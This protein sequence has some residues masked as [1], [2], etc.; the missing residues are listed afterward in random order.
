MARVFYEVEIARAALRELRGG[1]VPAKLAA[2]W[3]LEY[4]EELGDASIGWVVPLLEYEK[5]TPRQQALCEVFGAALAVARVAQRRRDHVQDV[6][7]RAMRSV[8]EERVDAVLE[9][10]KCERERQADRGRR[11]GYR[12]ARDLSRLMY[13][14]HLGNGG[15]RAAAAFARDLRDQW[16]PAAPDAFGLEPA[17]SVAVRL[18]SLE[19]VTDWLKPLEPNT[20]RR[21]RGR[22]RK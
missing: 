14:T 1:G 6:A 15:R 22:P 3:G 20:V 10:P 5:L 9:A 13:R 16:M 21:K 2:C 11:K 4:D 17:L 8:L 19:S 12:V 7:E 18:P